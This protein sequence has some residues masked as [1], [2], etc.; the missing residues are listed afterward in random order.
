MSLRIAALVKKLDV[1]NN[2]VDQRIHVY[3]L[4]NGDATEMATVLSNLSS[5]VG[6][7]A[8]S[9]RG[10]AGGGAPGSSEANLFEGAVKKKRGLLFFRA[11]S[12]IARKL[13]K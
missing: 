9:R 13:F 12:T 1:Q 10:G 5:G 11:V 4:E 3:Y 6:A 2:D 7:Q 8:N